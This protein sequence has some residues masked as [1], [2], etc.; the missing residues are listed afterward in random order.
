MAGTLTLIDEDVLMEPDMMA[1]TL[2][3]VVLEE[4]IVEAV[5]RSR[6]MVSVGILNEEVVDKPGQP[7]STTG[8]SRKWSK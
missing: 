1:T 7:W 3:R 6:E 4:I 2:C 8:Y 5:T